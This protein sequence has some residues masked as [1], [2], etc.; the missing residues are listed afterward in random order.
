MLAPGSGKVSSW[1]RNMTREKEG[2]QKFVQNIRKIENETIED[3][4]WVTTPDPELEIARNIR[5]KE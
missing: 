5:R 4:E 3:M 2:K 1:L